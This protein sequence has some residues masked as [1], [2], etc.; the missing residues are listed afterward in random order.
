MFIVSE[1][2]RPIIRELYAIC[3]HSYEI[4]SGRELEHAAY[5]SN[6]MQGL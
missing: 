1:E 6:A 2:Q 4:D 5:I 3:E